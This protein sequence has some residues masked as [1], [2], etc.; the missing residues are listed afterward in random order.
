MY[1]QAF[2]I[3]ILFFLYLFIW[4]DKFG[5]STKPM[6]EVTSNISIPNSREEESTPVMDL[7]ANRN[8]NY[9]DFG[10]RRPR[11]RRKTDRRV[12]CWMRRI[13]WMA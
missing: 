8:Y 4:D 7:V 11:R 2:Y 3:S 5:P 6:V 1:I 13:W 9:G 12:N 10:R